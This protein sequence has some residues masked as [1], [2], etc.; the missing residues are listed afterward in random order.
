MYN[1]I[2]LNQY[3]NLIGI[4]CFNGFVNWDYFKSIM[5]LCRK[6]NIQ[7][8]KKRKDFYNLKVCA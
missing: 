3:N 2:A 6:Y 7:I 4:K 1:L 5:G 8:M